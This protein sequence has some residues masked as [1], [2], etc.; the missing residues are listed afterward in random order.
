M[1]KSE[2]VKLLHD[3]GYNDARLE[4][5]IVMVM[6]HDIVKEMGKIEK[7]LKQNEYN[8][9]WGIR[10]IQEHRNETEKE[11]HMEKAS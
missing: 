9:S 8:M 3:N 1:N 5:G 7:L 11:Y 4:N 6:V 10:L 2:A